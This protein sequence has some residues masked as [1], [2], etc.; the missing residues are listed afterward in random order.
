MREAV[1]YGGGGGEREPGDPRVE[2]L[3]QKE[4]GNPASLS[5]TSEKTAGLCL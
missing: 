2:A 4:K 5:Y 1:G 3:T